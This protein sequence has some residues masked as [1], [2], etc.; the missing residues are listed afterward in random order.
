[1]IAEG[2]QVMARWTVRA[3]HTGNFFNIPPTGKQVT[4]AGIDIIRLAHGKAVEHWRIFDQL[5]L[6]HQLG[7]VPTP[8]QAS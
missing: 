5:G 3:T 7:V 1:M 2:E 8:G 6:L 4:I